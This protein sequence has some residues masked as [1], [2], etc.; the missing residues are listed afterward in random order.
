M[1]MPSIF[2]STHLNR[3]NFLKTAGAAVGA[4][5]LGTNLAACGSSSGGGSTVTVQHWDYYVSQSPWLDNEVKLFEAAHPNIKVKRIINSSTTYDELFNL[6]VKS[7][8]QPDVFITT[9]T[10]TPYNEQ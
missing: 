5:T 8:K 3:R 6:A 1:D 10:A 9:G 2:T 7:N 4:A